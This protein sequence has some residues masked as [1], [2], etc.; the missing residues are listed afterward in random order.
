MY[1][2]AVYIHICTY[3]LDIHKYLF[4]YVYIIYNMDTYVRDISIFLYLY[5]LY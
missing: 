3:P 2:K 4:T 5:P 1:L